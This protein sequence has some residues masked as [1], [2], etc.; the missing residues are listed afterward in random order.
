MRTLSI[1]STAALL[2]ATVPCFG[3]THHR[4]T[5]TNATIKH[6]SLSPTRLSRQHQARGHGV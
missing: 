5:A 6:S 1:L 4:S 2:C 3:I